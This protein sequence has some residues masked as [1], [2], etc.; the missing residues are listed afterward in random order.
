MADNGSCCSTGI[1][2]LLS[3]H[4]WTSYSQISTPTIPAANAKHIIKLAPQPL[5]LCFFSSWATLD[6]K[7]RLICPIDV[8]V[9][10]TP[11]IKSEILKKRWALDF[12]FLFHS[13]LI[14]A[15]TVEWNYA[16]KLSWEFAS[17]WKKKKWLTYAEFK[18]EPEGP[19]FHIH[20]IS[21][22]HIWK[23]HGTCQTWGCSPGKKGIKM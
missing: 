22:V 2:K 10:I 9:P 1:S 3:I 4:L 13:C 23:S 18:S 16:W 15:E 20:V 5:W 6:W 21:M 19:W 14:P 12:T 11:L 7:Q 8:F 17:S